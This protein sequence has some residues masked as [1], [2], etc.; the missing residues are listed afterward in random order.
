MTVNRGG[1]E[2]NLGHGKINFFQRGCNTKRASIF[3]GKSIRKVAFLFLEGCINRLL[4]SK[5]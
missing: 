2:N 1:Q 5:S 3:L 4:E